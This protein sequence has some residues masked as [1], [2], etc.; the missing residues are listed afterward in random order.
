M[1][2]LVATCMSRQSR[3]RWVGEQLGDGR[4][5]DEV[6]GETRMVAEGI[7]TSQAALELG[8]RAGVETPIAEQVAAVLYEG[9]SATDALSSLMHRVIKPELHGFSSAPTSARA[10]DAGS[11]AG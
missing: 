5:V 1:G 9:K 3:N 11:Q 7:R 8:R 10:A 6:T 4:R 2:D